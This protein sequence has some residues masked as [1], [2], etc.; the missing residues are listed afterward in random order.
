MS[1]MSESHWWYL[2][3]KEVKSWVS[4]TWF[5]IWQFQTTAKSSIFK[6]I[7]WLNGS[8]FWGWWS[9]FSERGSQDL[10][11][12]TNVVSWF[13]S[14]ISVF[15]SIVY[16]F[17]GLLY[18]TRFLFP[19]RRTTSWRWSNATCGCRGRFRSSRRPSGT[20]LSAWRRGRYWGRSSTP[21][22][23]WPGVGESGSK[24]RSFLSHVLQVCLRYLTR[25]MNTLCLRNLNYPLLPRLGQF[26]SIS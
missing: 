2:F 25:N 8:F 16:G 7:F 20:T 17:P 26:C 14:F 1:S 19:V 22:T 21:S 10:S 6:C 15:T 3:H 5:R 12:G 18:L 11:N 23:V 13:A 24:S 9:G 4:T